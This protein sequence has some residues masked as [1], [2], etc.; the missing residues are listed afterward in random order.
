MDDI[1]ALSSI[2]TYKPIPSPTREDANGTKEIAALPY[3][4]PDISLVTILNG[5]KGILSELVAKWIAS[6]GISPEKFFANGDGTID[7]NGTNTFVHYLSLLRKHFPFSLR[8][9]VLLAYMIREY[10]HT[11]SEN[12]ESLEYFNAALDCLETFKQ[13]DYAIKHGVIC[14]IWNQYVRQTVHTTIKLINRVGHETKA[15]TSYSQ[16][17]FSDALVHFNQFDFST[18]ETFINYVFLFSDSRIHNLL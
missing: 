1:A 11:W 17:E 18:K 7:D 12:I 6:T 3:T 8:S 14:I 9:G 5:G 4:V 10:M 2:L 16:H 13:S 15:N